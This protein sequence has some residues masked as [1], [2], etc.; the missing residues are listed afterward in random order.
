MIRLRFC[1]PALCLLLAACAARESGVVLDTRAV[2]P[3]LLAQ[4]VAER[5]GRVQTLTARGTLMMDAPEFSGSARF[6]LALCRTDSALIR[7]EGPFGLD[8]AT[9]FVNHK[10]FVAYNSMN[11][12]VTTGSTDGRGLEAVFPVAIPMTRLL[13]AFA[14]NITLPAGVPSRYEVDNDRFLLAYRGPRYTESYWVDP[15]EL[16]VTA[17]ALTDSSGATIL[18]MRASRLSSFDGF[19]LPRRVD[20][21]MPPKDSQIVISFSTQKPNDPSPSFAYTIPKNARRLER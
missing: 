13:E 1:V 14:G 10:G 15:A 7:I 20:I 19:T 3:D 2:A 6:E 11:N 17:F 5:S 9:V 8:L 16:L 21:Q 4:R 12:S 18:E